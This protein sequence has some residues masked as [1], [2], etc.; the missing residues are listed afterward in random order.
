[1]VAIKSQKSYW[2]KGRKKDV[3]F[4]LSIEKMKDLLNNRKEKSNFTIQ[5]DPFLNSVVITFDSMQRY[6]IK[7]V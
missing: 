5:G 1:M 3:S 6:G 7:G 4:Q 2:S